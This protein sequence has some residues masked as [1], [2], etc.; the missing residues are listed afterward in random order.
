MDNQPPLTSPG[1]HD[2][3]I[4]SE[5]DLV[6]SPD[7]NTIIDNGIIQCSPEVKPSSQNIHHIVCCADISVDPPDPPDTSYNFHPD[8]PNFYPGDR[9]VYRS[10]V[11]VECPFDKFHAISPNIFPR[12]HLPAGTLDPYNPEEPSPNDFDAVVVKIEEVFPYSMDDDGLTSASTKA[13]ERPFSRSQCG[14]C[15]DAKSYLDCHEKVHGGLRPHP[16]SECGKSFASKSH[17]TRHAINHTGARHYCCPEC[18]KSFLHK[19]D[20]ARHLRHHTGERPYVCS[21]CGLYFMQKGHLTRHL[22]VHTGEKP[23][24]CTECGKCFPRKDTYINHQQVHMDRMMYTCEECGKGFALR[25]MFILHQR[26]HS[27]EQTTKS[28]CGGLQSVEK[29]F[30]WSESEMSDLVGPHGVHSANEPS[31]P[32]PHTHVK[33]RTVEKPFLCLECGKGYR[34]KRHLLTHQ[35]IHTGELPF[36]CSECAKCFNEKRYLVNHQRNHIGLRPF[37]CSQCGKSFT[38]KES[39]IRHKKFHNGVRPHSCSVCGKGFTQR[40]DLIRHQRTHV[41]KFLS[42]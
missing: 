19:S 42:C 4:T 26:T 29:I 32:V 24:L 39:L 41:D 12:I 25:S 14:K 10:N 7:Y 8:N 3:R 21:E 5:E 17:L 6:Y 27:R 31:E 37:S 34:Q 38:W 13:G 23:F 15:F 33:V 30:P 9:N 11:D 28:E 1:G 2:V 20:L 18:R 40:G 22:K 36:K 16:C 35:R